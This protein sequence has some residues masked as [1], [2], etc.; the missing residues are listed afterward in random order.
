MHD[1]EKPVEGLFGGG[2]YGRKK[3]GRT[4]VRLRSRSV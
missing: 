3:R 4:L 2:D 1:H